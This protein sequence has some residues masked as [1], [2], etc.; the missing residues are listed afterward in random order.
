MK[1]ALVSAILCAML[2]LMGQL[3]VAFGQFSAG[4]DLLT[5]PKIA[6]RTWHITNKRAGD[7][8][9]KA[10]GSS[11][12]A[13]DY[14]LSEATSF[15]IEAGTDDGDWTTADTRWFA[16]RNRSTG[17][18]LTV[19]ES[20]SLPR[21]VTLQPYSPTS[22]AQQFRLIEQ[23]GIGNYKLR[24]R[25]SASGADL[26]LET[27]AD[28]LILA[29]NPVPEVPRQ[30]FSFNLSM[31]SGV[32]VRYAIVNTKG[33]YMSDNGIQMDGADA[34]QNDNVDQSA[35]WAL[36][37][38]EGAFYRIRNTLTQQFLC[39]PEGATA[40]TD[41]KMSTGSQGAR[42]EWELRRANSEFRIVNREFSN[43]FVSLNF[44]QPGQPLKLTIG[45]DLDQINWIVS[46]MPPDLEVVEGN[47]DKIEDAAPNPDCFG[48][49]G[50]N[51]K[52]GICERAGLNPAVTLLPNG[53]VV[54]DINTQYN[55][56]PYF[57]FVREA[58]AYKYGNNRVDEI[59]QKF[60]LNNIGH[61]VDLALMVRHY[62]TEGLPLLP[63]AQW[64]NAAQ[65]AVGL[66][67]ERAQQL[68]LA[69]ATRLNE[70]WNA[71]ANANGQSLNFLDLYLGTGSDG[72]VWPEY[73]PLDSTSMERVREY[74]SGA[75]RFGERNSAVLGSGAIGATLV[76]TAVYFTQVLSIQGITS[77]IF[78][79]QAASIGGSYPIA[80]I[81]MTSLLPVAV[82]V[83]AAAMLVS[84]VISA[85]EFQDFVDDFNEELQ[86]AQTPIDMQAILTGN[87]LMAR[88]NLLKDLDYLF[89]VPPGGYA[90]FVNDNFY[91]P[92][93]ELACSSQTTA[94]SLGPD[95]LATVNTGNLYAITGCG[96]YAPIAP[97][98][99]VFD[100]SQTGL[101]TI[102]LGT[103][104]YY[105]AKT[106]QVSIA[107]SDPLRPIIVC[108]NAIVRNTESNGCGTLVPYIVSAA[109]N[110]GYTL[111]HTAGGASGALFEL[112]SHTVTW[113]ASDAANNTA[114]CSFSVTVVDNQPPQINCPAHIIRANAAGQCGA[115]VAYDTPLASDN[116]SN[117]TASLLEGLA[118]SSTFPIGTSQ[119]VWLAAD[120]SGNTRTCAFSVTVYDAQAP[121][122]TCPANQAVGTAPNVC[123]APVSFAAPIASDNCP[124][125]PN[126][127]QQTSGPSS[128]QWFPKGQTAV[129]FRVT[130]AAGLTRTC[131]FR[132]LV[133]DAQAPTIQCPASYAV[134]ATV[135]ECSATVAY[136]L[137]TA[138]D[139]CSP[140]PTV[141]RIGGP[142]PG[143][144]FSIG[145]TQVTWRAVD[146]ASRSATC[147]FS[148]VVS[149]TQVPVVNC[150]GN[151]TQTN[152]NAPVFYAPPTASDNCGV[153]ALYLESGGSS[154][155]V[156]PV[157]SSQ[158]TW[159]AVDANGLTGTCSF[160]ITV[161]CAGPQTVPAMRMPLELSLVPNPAHS[162]VLIAWNAAPSADTNIQIHDA[163]GR[164]IWAQQCPAGQNQV[165]LAVNDWVPGVYTIAWHNG[166]TMMTKR[167]VVAR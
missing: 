132:V 115:V 155:S 140:A 33:R 29:D 99:L 71:F 97:A 107:V 160:T 165:L 27:N 16:I 22:D 166:A 43:L 124:L 15:F 77:A 98:S 158:V 72:F 20:G 153:N 144:A 36:D 127:L 137:P 143:T 32:G 2:L 82:A 31:P 56:D 92:R 3:P 152:C 120:G 112:G 67:Q 11:V 40:G 109:D 148:V 108:P 34:L 128:G 163:T 159:R 80:A 138:F 21:A 85:L 57:Q 49:Y 125:P 151:I 8:L 94:V 149:D 103:T 50:A 37:P 126:A 110:C 102:T 106:C 105:G 139:N 95:G 133:N 100:C 65:T 113:M 79:S 6:W 131:S 157:G 4:A 47:Y 74:V 75:A 104:T 51:F 25:L 14:E 53:Q 156:F 119:I 39:A 83:V 154:G 96:D 38:V 61:R 76:L 93:I 12:S 84:Q 136:A 9:L 7:F 58:I 70:A 101:H 10:S 73:Y 17:L 35:I 122:L 141:V 64:S 150:P 5:E 42:T 114:T 24:S 167:L 52:K 90:H 55:I 60:D 147:T 13:N 46:E 117:A 45:A 69:Y 28:G 89:S 161:S 146:G 18:Y 44:K 162:E 116:C 86:F 1:N 41:I 121:S 19:A 48:G 142:A 23:L 118:S 26:V 81:F 63:A 78:A 88:V 54:V 111:Q 134:T 68:R 62:L 123:A 59:L 66:L 91:L 164:T 129:A 135:G 130:D 30:N 87:N 145:T